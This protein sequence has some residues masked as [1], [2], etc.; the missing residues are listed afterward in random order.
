MKYSNWWKIDW[1]WYNCIENSANL[2]QGAHIH[3]HQPTAGPVP[4]ACTQPYYVGSSSHRQLFHPY[5]G[6]PVWQRRWVNEQRKTRISKPP[7][8]WGEC[9]AVYQVPAPHSTRGA[10][11][12]EPHGSS[13]TTC[14]GKA[15]H[16]L[17]VK[18]IKARGTHTQPKGWP[19]PHAC[20]QPYHAGSGSHGQ[21]FRP[22]WSSSAWH[23]RQS[24]TGENPC[25][26]DPFLQRRVFKFFQRPSLRDLFLEGLIYR[27][28][29]TF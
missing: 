4:H 8:C 17:P 3:V 12:W 20:T 13:T 26:K 7:Y 11:R 18:L 15:D 24:V 14:A 28:K 22:Y 1:T 23:S 6:P 27:G 16:K 21:L 10:V 5:W 25:I 9:K 29:L 19:L 2:E